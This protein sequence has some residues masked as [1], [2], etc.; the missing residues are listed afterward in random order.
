LAQ[1]GWAGCFSDPSEPDKKRREV[2]YILK[3]DSWYLERVMFLMAGV[4]VLVSLLLVLVHSVYWLI[5]TA[6]VGV[7]L[8]VFATTGF[9]PSAQLFHKLGVKPRLQSAN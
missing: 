5:L 3:N 1:T 6:L 4:M 9:C 8:V 7:N 2:M